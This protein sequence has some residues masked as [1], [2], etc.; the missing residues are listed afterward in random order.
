MTGPTH[1]DQG[2]APGRQD[3]PGAAGQAARALPVLMAYDVLHAAVRQI[4][5]LDSLARAMAA[6]PEPASQGAA[7][8]QQERWSRLDAQFRA[9]FA[10]LARAE[11]DLATRRLAVLDLARDSRPRLVPIG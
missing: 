9:A 11:A 7:L 3:H 1:R 2:D 10:E 6:Q 8:A 4:V 5:E